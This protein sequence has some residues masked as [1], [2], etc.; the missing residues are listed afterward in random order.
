M[1]IISAFGDDPVAI[2]RGGS[3]PSKD[4]GSDLGRSISTSTSALL[5]TTETFVDD[6]CMG[7][8][9]ELM[10][11]N[12]TDDLYGPSENKEVPRKNSLL[13][14]C[15]DDEDDTATFFDSTE[16][17]LVSMI[18]SKTSVGS[19]VSE[20]GTL[21]VVV[22]ICAN[23]RE[24]E[25]EIDL[26]EIPSS[27][28]EEEDNRIQPTTGGQMEKFDAVATDQNSLVAEST[29]SATT[30]H[31]SFGTYH[32]FL[33]LDT[34]ISETNLPTNDLSLIA[35]VNVGGSD[36][37]TFASQEKANVSDDD[38]SELERILSKF[39]TSAAD[40]SVHHD[41]EATVGDSTRDPIEDTD[42]SGKSTEEI[43]G[44]DWIEIG[45]NANPS[46]IEKKK[47]R[48]ESGGERM[49]KEFKK[50]AG[51]ITGR[52]TNATDWTPVVEM[53][54]KSQES[55]GLQMI[56]SEGNEGVNAAGGNKDDS[57]ASVSSAQDTDAKMRN[58]ILDVLTRFENETSEMNKDRETKTDAALTRITVETKFA[59]DAMRT[60]ECV[61]DSSIQPL[62]AIELKHSLDRPEKSIVKQ[63]KRSFASAKSHYS[64]NVTKLSNLIAES[65]CSKN[66]DVVVVSR[67]AKERARKAIEEVLKHRKAAYAWS[68]SNLQQIDDEKKRNE[69]H[70]VGSSSDDQTVPSS[71]ENSML[72]SMSTCFSEVDTQS[73]DEVTI[74]CSE[75][76]LD[77]EVI[78]APD[79][80]EL[81]AEITNIAQKSSYRE[82]CKKGSAMWRKSL[83]AV[84]KY[85]RSN[86]RRKNG[87]NY[88]RA[89]EMEYEC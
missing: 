8:E 24:D 74:S 23:E 38:F 35:E 40:P 1:K 32:S 25:F 33:E 62:L 2:E 48:S 65:N 54:C 85:V 66:E 55:E 82:I 80:Y 37:P 42:P 14:F 58:T 87:N 64:K 9:S 86:K 19:G 3:E 12:Y 16:S 7:L 88:Q 46:R 34:V 70:F 67:V 56:E 47:W 13:L 60:T 51:I 26:I 78:V 72:D 61:E 21:P 50:A 44:E 52:K 39:N 76:N 53:G 11:G 73:V 84:S 28:P 63:I 17:S 68:L 41:A 79:D 31:K 5:S 71:I 81:F 15:E 10:S 49:M 18:P 27:T 22:D 83:I 77:I 59:S 45:I 20:D 89:A 36:A 4:S 30:S 57:S 29:A 75:K 43:S 69:E 6:L